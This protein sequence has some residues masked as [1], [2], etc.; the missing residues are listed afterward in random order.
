LLGRLAAGALLDRLFAPFV[1]VAVC[2]GGMAACLIYSTGALGNAVFLAAALLGLLVGAEFDVLGYLVRRYFGAVA[3][4]KIYG[5]IFAVFQ[6]G[7]ALG[8]AAFAY[9]HAAFGGYRQGLY[10]AALVLVASA[11]VFAVLPRYPVPAP[12]N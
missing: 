5:S 1:M 3:F 7:G 12:R 9:S 6:L 8:A 2:I 10:A 4:G 11:A